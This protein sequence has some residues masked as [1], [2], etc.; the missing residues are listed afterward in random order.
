[1]EERELLLRLIEMKFVN[2]KRG[3]T[4]LGNDDNV[5][6]QLTKSRKCTHAR[7]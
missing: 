7:M 3:T 2:K 6:S 4:F 5:Q 1:M